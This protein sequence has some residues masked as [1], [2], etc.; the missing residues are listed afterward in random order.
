MMGLRLGKPHFRVGE[1]TDGEIVIFIDPDGGDELRFFENLTY[2]CL[3]K[4]ISYEDARMI[5]VTL[6]ANIT[7]I[8]EPVPD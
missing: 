6:N 5:A 3:R 4:D 2:L 8:A 1:F 7:N